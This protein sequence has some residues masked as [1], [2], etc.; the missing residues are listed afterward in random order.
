MPD[1]LAQALALPG[2]GWLLAAAFAAGLVRGFSGFGTALV[3]LPIAA[4]I[5]DPVWAVVILIVMDI[6]GPLPAIPRAL[7]EGHPKDLAR[8]SLATLITIPLGLWALFAVDATVF[9]VGI[10]ATSL[11][12]LA[13]LLSGWRYRG[14]VTPRLVWVTGGTAG[15]LGGAVGV[16]GPPVILLYMASAHPPKVIR[17]NTTAYLYFYDWIMVGAFLVTGQLLGL[18][19]VLGLLALV[20]NL[21][22]N[23]LGGALF[24][25]EHARIYRAVAYTLIALSSFSALRRTGSDHKRGRVQMGWP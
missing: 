10:S 23:L 12:M 18:P 6:A 25:P 1:L 9:K 8:L 14:H 24:N 13:V 11:L 15:F 2:L 21:A 3:F 7:K 22:G 4:Q 19:L 17:S 20:P 5:V 16:P